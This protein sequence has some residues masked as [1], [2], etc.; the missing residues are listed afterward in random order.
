MHCPF[1]VTH[2]DSPVPARWKG[3]DVLDFACGKAQNRTIGKAQ[4]IAD[5]AFMRYPIALEPKFDHS[6]GLEKL[7]AMGSGK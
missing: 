1:H 5:S 4:E 2:R 7:E 6:N 3:I